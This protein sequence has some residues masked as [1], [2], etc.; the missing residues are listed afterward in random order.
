MTWLPASAA[1]A[2]LCVCVCVSASFVPAVPM[3]AQVMAL[4]T[5]VPP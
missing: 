5:G 2:G 1:P 3:S 4:H